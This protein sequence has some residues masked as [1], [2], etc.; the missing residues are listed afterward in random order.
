MSGAS[1][2]ALGGYD[3]GRR[4]PPLRRFVAVSRSVAVSRFVAVSRSIIE[5][6]ASGNGELCGCTSNYSET[7]S[8]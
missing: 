4:P 2:P 5:E 1:N 8:E 7:N 3:R 6:L